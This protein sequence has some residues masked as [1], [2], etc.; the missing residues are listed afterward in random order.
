MKLND[1]LNGLETVSIT[2]DININIT[3]FLS[4]E[5]KLHKYKLLYRII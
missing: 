4:C 1:I 2:G 3:I 5:F